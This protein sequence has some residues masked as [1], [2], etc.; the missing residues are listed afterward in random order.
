[1]GHSNKKHPHRTIWVRWNNKRGISL[2]DN[3]ELGMYEPWRRLDGGYEKFFNY[4]SNLPRFY[5]DSCHDLEIDR[6]RDE[7]GKMH[8]YAPGWIRWADDTEQSNNRKSVRK[9]ADGTPLHIA[10]ARYGL[11]GRTSTARVRSGHDVETAATAP[12]GMRP[13]FVT[14]AKDTLLVFWASMGCLK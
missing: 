1:M 3:P 14:E 5:E 10:A 13:R 7:F 2:E 6:T 11:D 12:L 4:V 9:V 8:G